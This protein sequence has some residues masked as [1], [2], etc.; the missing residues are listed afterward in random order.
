[1]IIVPFGKPPVEEICN[2]GPPNKLDPSLDKC[3]LTRVPV[4][5]RIEITIVACLIC[6][7]AEEP[8]FPLAT[9]ADVVKAGAI[10]FICLL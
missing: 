2:L 5:Q 6:H 4:I 3:D 9:T 10:G 1:M 8:A 7:S